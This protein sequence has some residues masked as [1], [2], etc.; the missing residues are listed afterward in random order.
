MTPGPITR[1]IPLLAVAALALLPLAGQ[2]QDAYPQPGRSIR[3]LVGFAAGGSLDAQARAVAQKVTEQSGVQVVVDNKPGASTMLAAG[4][5]VRA[6]PDGYT[7]LYAPSSTFAQNPHTLANVPYDPFRDF[8]PVTLAARGPLV[9]T[10]HT[11]VPATNVKELVAWAKANPGKLSFASFG[12]GT[13]SHVYAEAFAKA[14]GFEMVHVP[15]KG[16]A[17]AARDLLEGRVQA[18]FDA[19]PTAITNEK[20]GKIRILGVAAPQRNPFLPNVPTIGEQGVPG[21]DLASWVA[22]VAPPKMAPELL[23]KVNALFVAA[24]ASK[25]VHDTIAKGAYETAPSTPA[26]L[27]AEM[28]SAYDRWGTMI[29]QIGFQKQ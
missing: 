3:L 20:T 14:A 2:A 26:E 16:T 19:A 10:L 13:S 17:D 23:A 4:E 28:R 1:R 7:L 21:I 27:T 8:T 11:S 6:A 15:Y 12:V 5:V 9:L 18:Y 24:L 29:R 25:D 22:I